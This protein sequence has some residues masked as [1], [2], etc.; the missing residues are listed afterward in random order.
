[1]TTTNPGTVLI[2]TAIRRLRAIERQGLCPRNLLS[3]ARR[4]VGV[5]GQ[6][7]AKALSWPPH[8]RPDLARVWHARAAA[9]AAGDKTPGQRNVDE[10]RAQH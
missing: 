7:R 3:V 1:M 9:E 8:T 5:T 10:R 4:L 2:T 6:E